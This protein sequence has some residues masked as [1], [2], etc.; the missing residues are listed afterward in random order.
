M[1]IVCIQALSRLKGSKMIFLQPL[2]KQLNIL[3]ADGKFN[4]NNPALNW[5]TIEQG[6]ATTLVAAFDPKLNDQPSAYLFDCVVAPHKTT[7]YATD[8]VTANKLWNI[9]EEI[10]DEKFVI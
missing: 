6:A 8:P 1:R 4:E 10:L 2:M 7:P 5:K 3:T 9:T